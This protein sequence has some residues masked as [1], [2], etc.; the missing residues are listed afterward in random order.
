MIFFFLIFF[1]V[2]LSKEVGI[3]DG[4]LV[5]VENNIILRSDIEEQVYFLAKERNISPQKTPLAFE[6]L[7]GRVLEDQIER[8]VVLSFAK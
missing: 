5:V 3:V 1:C 8:L 4:L 6:K 2:G 7:Y